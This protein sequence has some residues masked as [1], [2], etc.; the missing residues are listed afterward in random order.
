MGWPGLNT[1]LFWTPRAIKLEWSCYCEKVV[2][3]FWKPAS[4]QVFTIAI[5]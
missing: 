4:D 1:N 3:Y 5:C 2:L